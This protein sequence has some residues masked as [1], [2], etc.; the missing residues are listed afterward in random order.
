MASRSLGESMDKKVAMF[1]GAVIIMIAVMCLMFGMGWLEVTPTQY[2]DTSINDAVYD[3]TG[4]TDQFQWTK[5]ILIW[6]MLMMVAFLML[7]IKKFEWGVCLAVL[8]SAAGSYIVYV[9]IQEFFFGAVWDE[10]L[11]IRAVICAIT[12]VIAIGVFLGT[13]KMWHYLLVG[14]IFA[15][16]YALL[17]W[18]IGGG[19]SIFGSV[20]TDP[21]GSMLVHMCAAYFGLGVA[22][23]I[24][25]KKAFDEPMYTTTHSVSFVWLAS[26]ILWVLWP[27]FVTSLLPS[28]EVTWGT[29]TCYMAG[30]GSIISAYVVCMLAQ[31]KVN[32][33]TYTYALLAGPVAI[34]AALLSVGPWGALAIGIVAGA[35]SALCF[36]YLQPWFC[37]K[38]GVLDVMGVHNLHGMAGWTGAL[39]T[40]FLVGSAA[41]LGFAV[42]TVLITLIGGAVAGVAIRLTMGK[43]QEICT[44]ETDFIRNDAPGMEGA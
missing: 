3:D 22:L 40:C 5:N 31:G 14:V 38:I 11:M 1:I 39:I 29:I 33:L 4:L 20:A 10:A 2:I 28:S 24:R 13:C 41:N 17:E 37:S 9:A 7:F 44:D 42:L 30:L 23:A 21:G 15:P 34:G 18:C 6:F 8:L 26:L 43:E 12:V 19:L 36:I 35:V 25:N 16:F 27:A 32:P